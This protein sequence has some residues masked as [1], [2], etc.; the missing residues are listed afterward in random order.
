MGGTVYPQDIDDFPDVSCGT[1]D[2]PADRFNDIQDAIEAIETKVGV[3]DSAVVTTI[4]YLLKN[5][6]SV[7]PGH[8]HTL[9]DG[10][11][12]VTA[13][14]TELN[15]NDG[16]IPGTSVAN[17]TLVLGANKNTDI[18]Q[19]DQGLKFNS[20]QSLVVNC[21]L[22]V[23]ISNDDLV[24]AVKTLDD[25]DPS[26]A[27]PVYVR[28]GNTIRIL[29]T[30]LSI[31]LADGTNWFG[32]GSARTAALFIDYF[33]YLGWDASDALIFLGISRLPYANTYAA[34]S[35]TNTSDR[36]LA[37]SSGASPASTD[38]VEV[39]G[40]FDAILSASAGFD[41]S[42]PATPLVINRPIYQTRWMDHNPQWTGFSAN[43]TNVSSRYMVNYSSCFFKHREGTAGTSNATT[44][45]ISLPIDSGTMGNANSRVRSGLA[46]TDNGVA[47]TNP[48]VISISPSSNTLSVFSNFGFA[49]FT[50]ANGKRADGIDCI[51]ELT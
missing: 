33:V 11:V 23:T 2:N 29:T 6:A 21:K 36:Y 35:A 34:F 38:E 17:K 10:A 13:S 40:R 7:D 37:L 4:D 44:F 24:V 43:P 20:P 8:K 1:T 16:S 14:A 32:S 47:L 12:D 48:G 41:W 19:V 25:N 51:F 3:D 5:P 50:N 42:L 45:T 27:R 18:L 30:A 28:I 9:A 26:A 39:I 31:T 22:S 15:Y 49:A 46:V